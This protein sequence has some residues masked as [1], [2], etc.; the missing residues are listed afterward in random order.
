MPETQKSLFPIYSRLPKLDV[1][2]SNPI[3]RSIFSWVYGYQLHSEHRLNTIYITR[4]LF[5]NWFTITS[6]LS[7]GD[8]V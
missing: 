7:T 4:R 5:S 6:L 2:G 8:C 3:S 1:V